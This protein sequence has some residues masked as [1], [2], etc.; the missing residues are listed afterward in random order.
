MLAT[1]ARKRL[2][3]GT[4]FHRA[5]QGCEGMK[6]SGATTFDFGRR[7]LG[8]TEDALL[9]NGRRVPPGGRS[10]SRRVVL[11]TTVAMLF[12]GR[13]G[14]A[15]DPMQI[16]IPPPGSAC[17]ITILS[18]LLPLPAVNAALRL[19]TEHVMTL[20]DDGK[21]GWAFDLACEG[22]R[23]RFVLAL[24]QSVADY[25]RGTRVVPADADFQLVLR[26]I[27]PMAPTPRA[28]VVGTIRAC[29]VA[30]QFGVKSDL[31]MR[32]VD[33]GL[34]KAVSGTPRHPGPNGSPALIFSSVSEFLRARRI[35]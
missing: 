14:G 22:A 25:Q 2:R 3:A 10:L 15:T 17:Q 8:L 18:P 20:I 1:P 26:L 6:P 19:S 13:V 30:R 4:Y 16:P 27:F 5:R 33:S 34:V 12:A 29:T 35:V 9:S 7:E 31:I 24:A 21:I 23:N 11:L 32:F 28:G